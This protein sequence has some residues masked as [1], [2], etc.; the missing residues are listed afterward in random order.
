MQQCFLAHTQRLSLMSD[1]LKTM[2]EKQRTTLRW[3]YDWQLSVFKL[4]SWHSGSQESKQEAFDWLKCVVERIL[5]QGQIACQEIKD[6]CCKS[7][8]Y[9]SML[10]LDSSGQV[11][12]KGFDDQLLVV[13]ACLTSLRLTEHSTCIAK[14]VQAHVKVLSY[15]ESSALHSCATHCCSHVVSTGQPSHQQTTWI[16]SCQPDLFD[17]AQSVAE[18]H[19]FHIAFGTFIDQI[20]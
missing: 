6:L 10:L 13:G 17:S 4:H 19:L 12:L 14:W 11:D 15:C 18:L 20:L 7:L 5:K 9:M 1:T 16:W 8:Y 2:Q 3:L